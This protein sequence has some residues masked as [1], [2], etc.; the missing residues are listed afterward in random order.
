MLR[1]VASQKWRVYAWDATT[2]LAKTGDAAN[3]SAHIRIDDGSSAA[4]N[5]TNPT[6]ASSTNEPGYY[7]FDLTQAETNGAKLSLA[8]KSSTANVVVVACPP[9]VY[10]RPQYF[11]VLGI[12]SD[13]HAHADLKEIL[14]AAQSVTDLKD[15]ADTGYDPAT[16]KVAGLSALGFTLGASDFGTDWLTSTGLAASAVTERS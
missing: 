7:D 4:T 12:E 2:G 9:V 14:G 15:F 1:N 6:E 16:H 8:P 10:T 13:G 5:D 11:S 3:I